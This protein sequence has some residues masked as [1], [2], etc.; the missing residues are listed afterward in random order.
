MTVSICYMFQLIKKLKALKQMLRILHK[1]NFS[2][3]E[4]AVRITKGKLRGLQDQL[5]L[6]SLDINLQQEEKSIAVEL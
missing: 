2:N 3:I 1:R 6:T 4:E 5:Q